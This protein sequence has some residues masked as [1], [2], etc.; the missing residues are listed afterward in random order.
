MED[1]SKEEAGEDGTKGSGD[2]LPL[3]PVAVVREPIVRET[4][5]RIERIPRIPKIAPSPN[6]LKIAHVAA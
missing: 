3:P 6:R 2:T 5:K 4:F 1:A